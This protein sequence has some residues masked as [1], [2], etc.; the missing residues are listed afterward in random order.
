MKQNKFISSLQTFLGVTK[1]ELFF[2]A[3]VIVGLIAGIIIKMTGEKDTHSIGRQIDMVYRALDSL[4][5][6]E[7]TTYTGADLRGNKIRQ[8]V[9]GDTVVK[10][11]EIFPASKK[12]TLPSAPVNI[13][14]ASKEEL[15]KLPGVGSATAEKII[16]YRSI[17]PFY[18]PSDIMKIKGIG[19][20]KFAKMKQ[21]IVVK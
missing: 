18:K 17:H 19:K 3:I 2:I 4:A 1:S 10:P 5:E 7:K 12:K 16:A 9:A 6:V 14:T 11:D 8:L 20:K 13:N 15:M 21:Y